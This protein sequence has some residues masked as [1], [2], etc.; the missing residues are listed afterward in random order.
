MAQH[1][2]GVAWATIAQRLP[3]R[4]RG[5]GFAG[6]LQQRRN[7]HAKSHVAAKPHK[8]IRRPGAPF[9]KTKIGPDNHMRQP[10]AARDHETRKF[11]RGQPGKGGVE[12]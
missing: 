12:I 5:H 4:G 10:K 11:F 2:G 9:A 6:P 8:V 7:G 1:G 3:D